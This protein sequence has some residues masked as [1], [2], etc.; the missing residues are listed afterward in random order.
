MKRKEGLQGYL[1]K[2]RTPFEAQHRPRA[3]TVKELAVT[4]HV[5]VKMLED[6]DCLG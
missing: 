5:R 2:N 6:G 4:E 3:A 1:R